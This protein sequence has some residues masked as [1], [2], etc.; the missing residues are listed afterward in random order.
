MNDRLRHLLQTMSYFTLA[1]VI[2]TIIIFFR[3]AVNRYEPITFK[4]DEFQVLTPVVYQ[5]EYLSFVIDY[6]KNTN[7]TTTVNTSYVDGIIYQTPDTPQPVFEE[8]CGVRNFLIYIPKALPAGKYYIQHNFHFQV[9][10]IR[11]ID[12]Q[13]RTE[14]FEVLER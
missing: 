13:A 1:L 11:S 10:P 5:G 2:A 14:M 3:W 7:V 8:G 12:I 6:C 9:N 4:R